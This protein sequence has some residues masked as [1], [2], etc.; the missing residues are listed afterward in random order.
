MITGAS[1]GLGRAIAWELAN[2]GAGLYL[3]GRRPDALEETREGCVKRNPDGSFKTLTVNL[4]NEAEVTALL[5]HFPSIDGIVLGAGMIDPFPVAF[6]GREKIDGMFQ[7]NFATAALLTGLL[8]RKKKCNPGCSIVFLSSVSSTFPHVGGGMYSAS[9]A[10]LEAYMRTLALEYAGFGIRANAVAPG[11][12][13]TEMYEEA[14]GYASSEV[15]DQHIT[16]YP[17]GVGYPQD[18]ADLTL[19]LLS[20]RSRWITGVT[21]P[22]D[23]GLHLGK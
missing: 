14:V 20:N 11:M 5:P 12:V 3:L 15:M 22:L 7:H 2:Q 9:K 17:L 19:F 23:G 1:S 10:A 6:L 16:K 4:E 21:I 18:V 8:L 13:L